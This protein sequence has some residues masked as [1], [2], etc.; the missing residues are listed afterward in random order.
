MT[1]TGLDEA[2]VELLE[3]NKAERDEMETEI[4]EMRERSVSDGD[5]I[6]NK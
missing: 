1:S 3:A 6:I 4:N 5:N 2:A